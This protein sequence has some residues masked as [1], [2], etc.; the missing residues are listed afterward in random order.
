MRKLTIPLLFLLILVMM[1]L[2]ACT[3][4]A[5][6]A[7]TDTPV[8]ATVTLSPTDT[9][10]PP[11]NTPVPPTDTPTPVPPTSTPMPTIGHITGTV[12]RSDTEEKLSGLR[13]VLVSESNDAS[14]AQTDVNGTFEFKDVPPGEYKLEVQLN[15]DTMPSPCTLPKGQR[16]LTYERNG[17]QI[18]VM[19]MPSNVNDMS[20]LNM[21]VFIPS[22]KITVTPGNMTIEMDLYCN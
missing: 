17:K 10:V 20:N 13:V 8:P 9:P 3:G 19:L 22:D 16:G 7:P 4:Q 5:A 6:P 1:F 18:V 14:F 21:F 15:T 11:T 12:F 2:A